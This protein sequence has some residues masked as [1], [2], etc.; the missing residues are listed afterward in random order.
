MRETS[1]G[2]KTMWMKGGSLCYILGRNELFNKLGQNKDSVK[3]RKQRSAHSGKV[4]G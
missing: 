3:R 4:Q 2:D 1:E